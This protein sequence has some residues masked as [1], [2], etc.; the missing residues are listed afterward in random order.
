MNNKALPTKIKIIIIIAFTI[1]LFGLILLIFGRTKDKRF[2]SYSSTPY[3]EHI[4]VILREVEKR[5]STLQTGSSSTKTEGEHEKS[6]YDLQILLVR[7]QEND[8]IDNIRI[9]VAGKNKNNYTYFD[10][11]SYTKSMTGNT[12]HSLTS[13]TSFASKEFINRHSHGPNGEEIDESTLLDESPIEFFILV[14]YTAKETEHSFAYRTSTLD[15]NLNKKFKKAEKREVK[16]S[17]IDYKEDPIKI[18]IT[19]DLAEEE[20]TIKEVQKDEFSIECVW[21]SNNLDAFKYSS[22]VL[23]GFDLRQHEISNPKDKEA[24]DVHPE[25]VDI[26]LEIYAKITNKDE[27]F[28]NYVKVYS[29]YGFYSRH[30]NLSIYDLQIDESLNLESFY[31][32]AELKIDNGTNGNKTKLL[33]KPFEYNMLY[34]VTVDEL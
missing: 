12:M 31:I 25:I 3:D 29:L 5:Q 34:Y 6:V 7:N 33:K 22:E 17:Y 26:K 4:G 8:D 10:Y 16:G 28:S 9:Y 15:F 2:E 21:D 13:A 1:V 19:K 23:E 27:D 20:S 11:S 18:R 14:T 24:W 32:Y 30:R